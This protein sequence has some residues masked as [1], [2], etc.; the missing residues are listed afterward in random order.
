MG[1]G[2]F[3]KTLGQDVVKAAGMMQGPVGA[4]ATLVE[5]F[6]P[7]QV[8]QVVDTGVA[9]LSA[10]AQVV[11][12][13]EATA[14]ATGGMTGAQKLAAA[15]PAVN[16]IVAAW[17]NSGALGSQEI[18]NSDT[19]KKGVQELTSGIADIQSSLKPKSA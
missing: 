18:A 3:L 4:A 8:K 15:L 17:L 16:Q 6:L 9:D 5:G 2:G 14:A 10:I 11:Q 7:G 1:F 12:V 19:F 13:V